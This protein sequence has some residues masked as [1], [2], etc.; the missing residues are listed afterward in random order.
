MS[1]YKEQLWCSTLRFK[2]CW[3]AAKLKKITMAYWLD[4]DSKSPS[5]SYLFTESTQQSQE[6]IALNLESPS[7]SDT[8]SDCDSLDDDFPVV[9]LSYLDARRYLYSNGEDVIDSAIKIQLVKMTSSRQ[10]IDMDINVNDVVLNDGQNG[11]N[12][13]LIGDFG[14][15]LT[16]T[17][18]G[19][20]AKIEY[21][22]SPTLK[23][24]IEVQAR[25][26]DVGGSSEIKKLYEH[27][28]CPLPSHQVAYIDHAKTVC[29]T[30]PKDFC[31]ELK[32]S[33]C[34]VAAVRA[35]TVC[36]RLQGGKVS[37]VHDGEDIA[38]R[39]LSWK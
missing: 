35:C 25:K 18:V 23:V 8:D 13:Q 22:Y 4:Q 33:G 10:I 16:V 17:R 5:S 21:E 7:Y 30:L 31:L 3:K 39:R 38:A 27:I 20:R 24:K 28:F 32:I 14:G 9:P 11:T 6:C 15:E 1:V 37:H 2:S 34:G 12:L 19:V 29:S 36:A 26:G